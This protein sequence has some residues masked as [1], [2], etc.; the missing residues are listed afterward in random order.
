MIFLENTV[1][2]FDLE[3]KRFEHA[4]I[5]RA[6]I[7]SRAVFANILREIDGVRIGR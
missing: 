2:A 7:N 1:H 6:A 5:D 3:M 4:G